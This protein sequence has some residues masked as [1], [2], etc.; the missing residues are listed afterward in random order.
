[1]NQGSGS[2]TVAA[3]TL[4]ASAISVG[5]GSSFTINPG[6]TV[7]VSSQGGITMGGVL[8]V[9]GT[10]TGVITLY[11]T[12][13]F[14]INQGGI[15]SASGNTAL[16]GSVTVNGTLTSG[17]LTLYSD[18]YLTVNPSATVTSSDVWT[19]DGGSYNIKGGNFSF[20]GGTETLPVGA[21]TSL[22]LSGGG[23][24]TLP[25]GT[26]VEN[27]SIASGTVV[28][29]ASGVN[30]SVENLILNGTNEAAGTWGYSGQTHNDTTYFTNTGGYLTVRGGGGGGSVTP[31]TGQRSPDSGL[32]IRVATLLANVTNPTSNTLTLVSVGATSTA[33]WSVNRQGSWIF[34]NPPTGFTNADNFS[35]VIMASNGLQATGT[36]SVAILV[37]NASLPNISSIEN[38]GNGSSRIH[39]NGIPGLTYTVQYTTNLATPS[40]LPVGTTTT[41]GYGKSIFTD[42]PASN[43]PPRFY[44]A[45]YP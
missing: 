27:L 22:T 31:F 28:S 45:T 44:R 25:A 33:G 34:Y 41:D 30:I 21:Y 38:L 4:T 16:Q 7:N 19:Y 42:S 26:S 13:T 20:S 17:G 14:T 5:N 32:K 10:L 9:S 40:W 35:Y 1:M 3:G 2:V 11:N 36:V 6:T 29:M 8:T 37:N 12:C 18:S 43:S 39:F 23:T 15:V 24:Y